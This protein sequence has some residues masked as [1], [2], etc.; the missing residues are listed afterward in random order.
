MRGDKGLR[1]PGRRRVAL[2]RIAGPSCNIILLLFW[3]PVTS[4]FFFLGCH[5]VHQGFPATL[6]SVE[7]YYKGFFPHQEVFPGPG[8]KDCS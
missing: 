4:S 7:M 3:D 5:L 1:S 2:V 8:M 6:I